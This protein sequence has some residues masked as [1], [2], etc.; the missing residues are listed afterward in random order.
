MKKL[1]SHSQSHKR[2]LGV[3][4]VICMLALLCQGCTEKTVP[5]ASALSMDSEGNTGLGIH[6]GSTYD[7]WA[8]AYGSYEV[9]VADGEN[10]VPYTVDIPEERKENSEDA[11]PIPHDGRFMIAAFYIDD[12]PTSV[13]DIA[14]AEGVSTEELADH[15]ASPEYLAD[16]TVVFRYMI[17]IIQDDVVNNIACDYLD[18]NAEL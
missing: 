8:T 17:F 2:V 9:Q 16:H 18:Y 6:A 3:V 10:Y 1:K 13:K 4:G 11:E 15:L 12:V 5:L 7:E 14:A